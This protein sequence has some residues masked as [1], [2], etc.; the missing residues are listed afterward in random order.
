MTIESPY[1]PIIYVR[2]YAATMAEIEETVAT[3]YMGFNLGATKIRQD[4]K[5]D[6]VRFIFESPLLRLMKDEGYVDTYANGD[7]IPPATKVAAKSV[8]IFRYYEPVSEDLGEDERREIEQFAVDLRR[9]IL[10]IRE[11]VC[12]GDNEARK[13]FKVYLVA[14]SM[15]GLICRSYLQKLCLKGS[16]DSDEDQTLELPGEHLVDK[17][18]T[19]ATP[20]N[21]IDIKGI[22]VPDVGSL[23]RLH[24]KNFNRGYMR[25]FL[26]LPPSSERV[27]G[28]NG[29]F[30]AERFFSMV[31][32]N[33]KDY[34]A[35]LG[36]SRKGTG[37][38]G[39]GLVMIS[40]AY[41]DGGPRAFCHRSHS[42]HYG[43]VNSEESYQNL[44]RFL[45]GQ[46]RV[47]AWLHTSEIT[48]PK[49]IQKHKDKGK[50]IRASYHIE[51]SG[52]IRG[53]NYALHERRVDQGS[54]IQRGYDELVKHQQPVYLFSS[55]LDKRSRSKH[56]TDTAMVFALRVAIQT[57]LYEVDNR[58]WLDEYIE[59][60]YV[61]DET[62]N[63]HVR[64][65]KEGK[66]SVRYGLSSRDGNAAPTMAE[67]QETAEGMCISVDLGFRENAARK[68]RPGFRG[69][70]KMH[71]SAWNT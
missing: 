60:G 25:G 39:D 59:G 19:Y 54:A 38:M 65:D 29:A 47:D 1:Y 70:L 53:L 28:L 26:D 17:V 34:D 57:P 63:F 56:S 10:R 69:Q 12:T 33:Y 50:K 14:H 45:F 67:M 55:Y 44:K 36:L 16:G 46:W 11:Q 42:G 48:L 31:G 4:Y 61:I 8:W 6:I 2:G 68:P 23:D 9:F 7:L 20:H 40:N 21:G 35:F 27:N 49:A 58:F 64:M 30:P 32:T 24:V 15:G 51:T 37:P 43:I 3:P 52:R 5:G 22:N 18:F 13:R 62:V 41:V 66:P 71:I